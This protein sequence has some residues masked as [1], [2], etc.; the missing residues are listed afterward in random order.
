MM[1]RRFGLSVVAGR[2][3]AGSAAS[4]P[5]VP[6]IVAGKR[7]ESHATSFHDVRDPATQKLVC[8]VPDASKDELESA[9]EAASAAFESWRMT[10]ITTRQRV[11]FKYQELL[12][13]KIDVIAESIVQENGKIMADAVGDVTR[14]L[15][16]VEHACGTATLMMG[17]TVENVSRD[18][19]TYSYRQPLGVVAGICPFNFP[20]MIPL[21]MFPVAVTCGNTCIIKPSE[22]TPGATMILA[23]LVKEA[24]LPDGVLNIVHGGKSTV[25]FL[26]DSP[27]IRAVSFV[28]SDVAGQHIHARATATGKR[29]Q[30]NLGAKNHATVLPDADKEATLNALCAAAFGASGQRCMALSVA[31]LVGEASEWIDDLKT[32]AQSLVV[33]AGH[34]PDA[35]LGPMISPKALERAKAIITRSIEQGANAILD[36]REFTSEKYPEGNFL[37]PTILTG[38]S[39]DMECYKQEIFGPVLCVMQ[40]DSLEEAIRITN[41]NSHGNGC[42]I[43][44]RSGASARKFQFQVDVGQVGINLPI[45]V[46]LPFFSFT[47]SRGSFVGANH[48]YGKEGVNFYTQIKTVTSNWRSAKSAAKDKLNTA[49]P[50]LK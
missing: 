42:A 45:P 29:V 46:P 27:S 5:A 31:I 3:W 34:E 39:P 11:M 16:V 50:I 43:F 10:P 15:E 12:R 44:T 33:N 23:G 48:F 21:W 40:A 20:A 13:K 6:L 24:G 2:R 47:G 17:E 28:G 35:Q 32:K 4:A 14:G 19:D 9:V 8:R 30:A 38:V 26:C 18:I 36:G 22:R 1:M 7:V 37:G 25:D 49:M 41:A